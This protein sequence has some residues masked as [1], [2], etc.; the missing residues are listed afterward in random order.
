MWVLSRDAFPEATGL[1]RL[2]VSFP[3]ELCI[4]FYFFGRHSPKLSECFSP[5]DSSTCETLLSPRH[6]FICDFIRDPGVGCLALNLLIPLVFSLPIAFPRSDVVPKSRPLTGD[7]CHTLSVG[8]CVQPPP[9]L[10]PRDLPAATTATFTPCL[11]AHWP[12]FLPC[13]PGVT[14]QRSFAPLSTEC[15]HN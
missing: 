15:I 8:C 6:Y 13:H 9:T 7:A 4:L 2:S 5:S 3:E 1:C 12:S 14:V 10:S 11:L